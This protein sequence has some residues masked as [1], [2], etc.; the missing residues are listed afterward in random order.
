MISHRRRLVWT[1]V[2][3][4]VACGTGIAAG[5][6]TAASPAHATASATPA[7]AVGTAAKSQRSPHLARVRGKITAES[8]N[9]WTLQT[10][11]GATITVVITPTTRIGK[12]VAAGDEVVVRGQRNGS[13]IT[14]IRIRLA[15][16]RQNASA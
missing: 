12:R 7:A 9:N 5:A 15:H 3:A 4:L 8:G 2:A 11:K 6:W 13:T 10:A 14:A 1:G 16:P